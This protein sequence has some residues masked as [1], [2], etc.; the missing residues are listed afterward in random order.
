VTVKAL[1]LLAPLAALLSGCE[2]TCQATCNKL[3]ECED[4]DT[5]R[6][7]LEE[8]ETS[9][10]NEENLYEAWDDKGKRE[11]LAEMKR[12]IGDEDCGD[13]ADGV[14]YDPDLVIW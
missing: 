2:P 5:P 3:L 8:C 7:S 4:V 9:C 6:L 1:A 12:C 14:C 11:K 13:I 10:R